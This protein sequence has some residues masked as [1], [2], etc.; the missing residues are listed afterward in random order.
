M[1]QMHTLPKQATKYTI[2]RIKIMSG[3][4][5]A[6]STKPQDGRFSLQTNH[7]HIDSRVSTMPTL[8]GEKIVLRILIQENIE[9]NFDEL[10][11]NNIQEQIWRDSINFSSGMILLV[12]PT[13]CVKTTTLYS[14]LLSINT[15]GINITTIEDPIE[16]EIPN[17]NQT[18][19]SKQNGVT[20]NSGL[21]SLLRQD[22]DV[23]MVGEIRDEETAQI[24]MQAALTGHLVFATLHTPDAIK[25]IARLVDLGIS[26][27]LL[28]QTIKCVLSQRLL[29]KICT[30]CKGNKDKVEHCSHCKHTGYHG[31]TAVFQLLHNNKNTNMLSDVIDGKKVKIEKFYELGEKLAENK[32]TNIKEVCRVCTGD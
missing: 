16:Y 7:K 2:N 15:Q 24:A 26:K 31:R 14:S 6:L 28:Q 11:F 18:Q 13:G 20:F 9:K 23:I 21:R 3:M 17:F 25:T 32:I 8:N 10:G 4:D 22:P 5:I 19:V 29:R 12:G 30:Q 27:N 1:H